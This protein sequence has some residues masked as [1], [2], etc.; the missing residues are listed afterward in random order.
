MR[1]FR[2]FAAVAVASGLAALGAVAATGGTASAAVGQSVTGCD[3]DHSL[4][5]AAVFPTCTSPASTVL[6]PT[7]FTI[8][9]DPSF[10]S[11]L[12]IHLPGLGVN[13]TYT[14]SCSVNGGTVTDSGSF[15]AT[16]PGT[17]TQVIDLQSAVGSPEPNSCTVSDLTATSTLSI[18]LLNILRVFTFGVSATADTGVQGAIWQQDGT[19]GAG[20]NADICVDDTEDGNAGSAVQVFQCNSDLAQDW[21]WTNGGELVRNGDCMDLNGN[22]V[23]LATCTGSSSQQWTLNGTGGNPGT[24]VNQNGDCLT[25]TSAADF[26]QFTVATCGSDQANQQWIAPG[27]SPA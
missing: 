8:N 14:L 17:E 5:A 16:D 13:V 20:A 24:I 25:A 6:N 11:V 19:S 23:I 3:I 10:L 22:D 1:R 12:G 21:I 15:L 7:S 9:V 26:T 18:N 2:K 4:L 27:Q